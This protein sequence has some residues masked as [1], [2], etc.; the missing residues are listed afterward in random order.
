MAD[1]TV[2]Y[3][4]AGCAK[5]EWVSRW[6]PTVSVPFAVRDVLTDEESAL[7]LADLGFATLPVTLTPDGHAAA[8]ADPAALISALP[9][10]AAAART[11]SGR[12]AARG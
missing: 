11:S 1:T 5:C 6:L 2:L 12:W 3:C 10:L 9:Q 8:G 4:R 7:E